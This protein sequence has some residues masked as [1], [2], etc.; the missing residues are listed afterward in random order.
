MIEANET[1]RRTYSVNCVNPLSAFVLF[2]LDPVAI[3]ISEES[4]D[5]VGSSSITI[6]L[7]CVIAKESFVNEWVRYLWQGESTWDARQQP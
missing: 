4:V 1:T 3:K 7:L 5:I 6:P 2:S